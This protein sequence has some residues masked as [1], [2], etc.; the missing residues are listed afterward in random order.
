MPKNQPNI[1]I[2]NNPKGK[3]VILQIN[4]F[5]KF[6]DILRGKKKWF[7]KSNISSLNTFKVIPQKIAKL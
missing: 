7:D 5:Y 6:F 1:T 3:P 2:L 4:N